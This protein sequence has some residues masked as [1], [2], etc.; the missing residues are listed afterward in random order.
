MQVWLILNSYFRYSVVG[1]CSATKNHQHEH[2][3]KIDVPNNF[4][5]ILFK[6]TD[7][8][9]N[10]TAIICKK[11][12]VPFNFIAII[13]K[14]IDVPFNFIAI[15]CKKIDVPNNFIAIICK[16]IDVPNN[17]TAIICKRIDVFLFFI[18]NYFT[19]FLEKTG[20][21]ALKYPLSLIKYLTNFH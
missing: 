7:I 14:R 5:T 10:F 13:C 15:I 3:K 12:D 17:F 1:D 21:T 19:G 4:I 11:I 8:P 2:Q 6:K 16:K 20:I 9:F 18:S